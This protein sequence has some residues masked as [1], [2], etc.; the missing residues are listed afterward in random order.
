MKTITI[1]RLFIL[2]TFI[3]V[4]A[5]LHWKVIPT[6]GMFRVS[7]TGPPVKYNGTSLV[8]FI[9]G[10]TD[11]AFAL[12]WF[13]MG[14]A[15]IWEAWPLLL[16]SSLVTFIIGFMLGE[17]CRWRYVIEQMPKRIQEMKNAMLLAASNSERDAAN[18]LKRAKKIFDE[19]QHIKAS[20]Q[21]MKEKAAIELQEAETMR[22]DLEDQA[23]F[24][25]KEQLKAESIKKELINAKA[26]IRRLEEKLARRLGKNI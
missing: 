21:A 9:E 23:Q 6:L 10:K 19:L 15:M 2:T 25:K 24:A 16:I 8:F 3:S 18:E 11:G 14:W 12:E 4:F 22:Q 13:K 26:K 17:F 20:T 5:W 1:I 7:L